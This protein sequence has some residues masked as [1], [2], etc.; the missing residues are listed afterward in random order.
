MFT[1]DRNLR[2]T[3]AYIKEPG[4]SADDVLGRSDHDLLD[5]GILDDLEEVEAL[6]HL[7]RQALETGKGTRAELPLHIKGVLRCFDVVVE[8]MLDEGQQVTGITCAAFDITKL[9]EAHEEVQQANHRLIA[10]IGFVIHELRAPVTAIKGFASSLLLPDIHWSEAEQHEFAAIIESEADK[11]SQRINDLLDIS[12]TQAESLKLITDISSVEEV[13]RIANPQL[14]VLCQQHDLHL[15]VQPELPPIR[16]DPQRIGQVLVNLVQNAAR[17][18]PP[19]T[20]IDVNAFQRGRMLHI[21]VCDQG[22]GIAPE[23]RHKVFDPFHQ[24]GKTD[25][26]RSGAGLGLAICKGLIEAHGGTIWIE[27]RP[28]PG[29]T[30]TF[31]LPLAAIP[32]RYS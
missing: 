23:Q 22:P 16:I 26:E 14:A 30:I 12:Q 1:Q 4:I 18:S 15:N 24:S 31:S 10:F 28:T 29:T 7:K 19:H 20:Q 32:H 13:L 6:E 27:D 9:K 21:E 3:W 25:A 2:R 5:A 17:Y 8:P 11:L